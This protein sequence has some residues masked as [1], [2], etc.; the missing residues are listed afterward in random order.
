[1]VYTLQAVESRASCQGEEGGR[2]DYEDAIRA[3]ATAVHDVRRQSV[4]MANRH[5]RMWREL[6]RGRGRGRRELESSGSPGGSVE[7]G[8][9]EGGGEERERKGAT[10]EGGPEDEGREGEDEEAQ[11]TQ[12]VSETVVRGGVCEGEG[13]DVMRGQ[14]VLELLDRYSQELVA[15]VHERTAQ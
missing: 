3:I 9:G 14:G 10:I 15:L 1:M 13:G 4:S 12:R 7:E 8:E 5:R 6:A 11:G 2:Q